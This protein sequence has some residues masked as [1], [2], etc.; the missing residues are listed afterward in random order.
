MHRVF[1]SYH[2]QNDQIYKDALVKWA[3]ENGV[4]IDGS[5]DTGDISDDLPDQTIRKIIRDE[6]LRDTTVTI[7]LC[8]TETA[9][10]KHVDWELYSS[11]IDGAVNKKSGI[12]VINL[13]SVNCTYY[14]AN[15]AGEKEN[16]F[17]QTKK[18][19]TLDR[20]G[21]ESR[22]PYMPKR[23]IDNLANGA[24]I[25]VINW[26]DVNSSKLKYMIERAYEDRAICKYSFERDMMK[27]NL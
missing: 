14:T 8:G 13:P 26:T 2:H 18:W 3:C 19:T 1:I 21:Y 20:A 7:L 24:L 23:I 22:Y 12:I 27:R 9:K 11:M 17:P 25:S 6:Y 4:F 15:H 10:R 16:V 5:V